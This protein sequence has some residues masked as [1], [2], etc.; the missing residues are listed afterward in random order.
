MDSIETVN[1][2][3]GET[4]HYNGTLGFEALLHAWRTVALCC[5]REGRSGNQQAKVRR[6]L[7]GLPVVYLRSSN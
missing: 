2:T 7:S 5:S 6:Q 3:P 4:L 1:E